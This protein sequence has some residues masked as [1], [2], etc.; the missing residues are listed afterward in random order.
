MQLLEELGRGACGTVQKG[1][2]VPSLTMVAV[3]FVQ[4][5]DDDRRRQMVRELKAFYSMS[6]APLDGEDEV[7]EDESDHAAS[8]RSL[9]SHASSNNGMIELSSSSTETQTPSG[10]ETSI[11]DSTTQ[12]IPEVVLPSAAAAPNSSALTLARADSA[13][14]SS[15]G[16]TFLR[17]RRK[18]RC[19]FI[20]NFYDAYTDP[21][22]GAV[23]IVLEYM[24]AGS[25]QDMI[26]RG[27]KPT[28]EMIATVAYSVLQGLNEIHSRQI[29]HRDV[30]PG[31]ILLSRDGRVKLSDFGIMREL[32][33][34]VNA[35]TFTGTMYY[36]SP[37]RIRG[38]KYSYQSDIWS[39]GVALITLATGKIPFPTDSGYWGLVGAIQDGPGPSL[40]DPVFSEELRSLVNECVKLDQTERPTAE[41]LLQ[42]PFLA[43]SLLNCDKKHSPPRI[44]PPPNMSSANER[45]IQYI[46]D[47]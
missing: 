3:K 44:V 34:T 37:E 26:N 21:E 39:L 22:R 29:I 31:N 10:V 5:H 7:E 15:E 38:E 35:R 40:S 19:P 25:L 42:H 1:I 11:D 20:V 24:N 30:K 9:V 33:D 16:Q 28:E 17:R 27:I 32:I 12:A 45:T 46:T 4:V 14:D 43:K 13:A 8:G 41:Q 2:Y 6:V 47:R 23:C 18:K 36:M